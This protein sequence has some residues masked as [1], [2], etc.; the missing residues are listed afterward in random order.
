MADENREEVFKLL[1]KIA[2]DPVAKKDFL[3]AARK[4][5]PEWQAPVDVAVD[6][7][8][9]EIRAEREADRLARETER[10]NA[11][12]EAKRRGIVERYG[13]D[14]VKIIEDDIMKRH[15]TA[16]YDLAARIYAAEQ[17][18]PDRER[19]D[20]DAS[21]HGAIWRMPEIDL[22]AYN[23]NP[24]LAARDAAYKLIDEFR[25]ART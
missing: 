25:K 3:R 19:R 21:R 15:G 16:D 14:A 22:K 1:D 12:L 4:V 23:D 11:A 24:K 17:P 6:E 5:E 20:Q 8:R 9:D 10:S 7:L 13:E 18:P 2:K